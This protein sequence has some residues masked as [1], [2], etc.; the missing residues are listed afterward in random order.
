[1]KNT[2]INVFRKQNFV[3]EFI[4]SPQ[5]NFQTQ[6]YQNNVLKRKSYSSAT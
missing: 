4:D 6:E 5:I 3:C 1:M 2:E